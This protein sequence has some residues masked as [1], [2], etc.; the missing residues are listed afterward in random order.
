MDQPHV[1]QPDEPVGH[2]RLD[3]SV[4]LFNENVLHCLS[5]PNFLSG[6]ILDFQFKIKINDVTLPPG[7]SEAPPTGRAELQGPFAFKSAHR[8][9]DSMNNSVRCV[10][11]TDG[12][13]VLNISRFG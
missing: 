9:L 11:S 7:G 3:K 1:H 2:Q 12:R 4:G 5:S 6:V 8:R 10:R 13:W